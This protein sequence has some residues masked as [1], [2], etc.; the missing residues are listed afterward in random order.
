MGSW[1]PG[2]LPKSTAQPVSEAA[3]CAAA[4]FKA[5]PEGR[6]L[7]CGCWFM[8]LLA[9]GGGL[10]GV[11]LGPRSLVLECVASGSTFPILVLFPRRLTP[12]S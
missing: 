1:P 7:E 12:C 5:P 2:G 6:C 8:A 11:G 3:L 10:E 9:P 4:L